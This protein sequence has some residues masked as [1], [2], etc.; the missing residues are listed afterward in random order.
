MQKNEKETIPGTA[1]ET[2]PG[3]RRFIKYGIA[4]AIGFGVAS[5]VELPILNNT[6][7]TDNS[8]ITNLN[9]QI[10]TLQSQIATLQE[11][12]PG[13]LT[14]NPTEQILVEAIAETM[15]PSDESGPG[16]K[17]AGVVYFIDRMLAGNYGKGG[18]MYLQGPFVLPQKGSVTVAGAI[19]PN[20]SKT[21]MSYSGGTITPRLQAGTAYQYA[22][23]PREFWRRG[24]TYLQDYCK[25]NYNANFE[26]L[27]STQQIQVLQDLFDNK[28]TN[29]TGGPSP[30]E[31][32]NELHDM[33][34]A[35]YWTDPLYGG[36]M[37][38]VGWSLLGF[39]GVNSGAAQGYTTVQL[40]T[41]DK[42]IPLPPMSLA[43]L[44]KGG[45]M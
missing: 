1:K 27:S 35:G 13:F 20:P 34:T 8:K 5:A 7:Q 12:G 26:K 41:S 6:I 3:R 28:P 14:L 25:S 17:E 18:N 19:F 23:N 24:L 2:N 37:G 22:F 10:S 30:P 31:L 9:N 38:M 11:S 33:V 45:Q 44:Q 21:Q 4:G 15:I 39:P 16:A 32:F 40:A 42:P 43:Q 36:N 29:F